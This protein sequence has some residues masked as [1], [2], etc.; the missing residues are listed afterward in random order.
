M[1]QVPEVKAPEGFSLFIDLLIII[2]KVQY[3]HRLQQG[4]YVLYDS[5]I[6]PPPRVG[7][8]FFWKKKIQYILWYSY[9]TVLIMQIIFLCVRH[10]YMIIIILYDDDDDHN[11]VP[12]TTVHT[13]WYQVPYQSIMDIQ[14]H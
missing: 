6:D 9:C 11:T 14:G 1:G 13:V 12:G 8:F 10:T 5:I 7:I 4:L 2:T 3:V